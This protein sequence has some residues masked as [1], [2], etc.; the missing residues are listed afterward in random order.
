MIYAL[1]RPNPL[2][3]VFG[4]HE[5]FHV[6]VVAGSAA[7]AFMIWGWVLAAIGLRICN[8]ISSGSAWAIV[9]I[10]ALIGLMVRVVL[11]FV[12]GNPT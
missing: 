10:F 6:F 1:K 12:S 9:I 3:R 4:F 7:F 2:P 11:A 5:I 8:R